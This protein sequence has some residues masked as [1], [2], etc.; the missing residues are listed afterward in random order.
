MKL[1]YSKDKAIREDPPEVRTGKK[2]NAEEEVDKAMSSS[3]H[4]D[5][6]GTVQSNR[7]GLGTHNFK[8]FCQSSAKERRETVVNEVKQV[9][10]ERREEGSGKTTISKEGGGP[11]KKQMLDAMWQGTWNAAADLDCSLVFPVVTASQCPDV[12]VWSDDARQVILP[13]LTVPWEENFGDAEE[14]K[15]RRYEELID[16]DFNPEYYRLAVGCRG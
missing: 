7:R 8:P 5:I 12:V 4:R 2:W 11:P 1:R 6:E 9:E 14:R 15:Y 10:R 13:E 3:R 16:A